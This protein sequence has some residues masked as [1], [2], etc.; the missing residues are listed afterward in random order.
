MLFL[1]G[2]ESV[3][4]LSLVS[5]VFS[6]SED[7]VERD[8]VRGYLSAETAPPGRVVVRTPHDRLPTFQG[9]GGSESSVEIEP[10]TSSDWET[11]FYRSIVTADGVVLI[12]GGRSTRIAGVLAIGQQIPV[13]ALAH[14][15]G[16]ARV[17]WQQLESSHSTVTKAEIARMARPWRDASAADHVAGVTDQIG[18]RASAEAEQMRWRNHAR[19][20]WRLASEPVVTS[21]WSIRNDSWPRRGR[22]YATATLP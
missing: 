16:G 2:V 1:V 5:H 21:W 17:I 15:G 11:S 14:F 22:P 6:D 3:F 4:G 18:R 13:V 12:G 20:A 8:V 19:R 7:Y 10:D 9:V